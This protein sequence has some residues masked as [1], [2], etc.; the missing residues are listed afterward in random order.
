MECTSQRPSGTSHYIRFFIFRNKV[1]RAL[2][3]PLI[4]GLVFCVHPGSTHQILFVKLSAPEIPQLTNLGGFQ[5]CAGA[6]SLQILLNITHSTT[7]I[8]HSSC[9]QVLPVLM[10]VL[11]SQHFQ[12]TQH[13]LPMES[14]EDMVFV[15]LQNDELFQCFAMWTVGNAWKKR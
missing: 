1:Q 6:C 3:E 4:F 2:V 7:L 13:Y 12:H 5:K 15:S 10:K 14:Q 9:S 8:P 11:R